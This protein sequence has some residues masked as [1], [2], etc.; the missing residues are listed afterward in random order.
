M[1]HSV[2]SIF[3]KTMKIVIYARISSDK[4]SENSIEAQLRVCRQW[5]EQHGHTVVREYVD[6]GFSAKTAKRDAFQQMVKAVLAGQADAIVVHKLDRFSRN[7]EDSITYKAML[8]RK[9]KQVIS[10]SEPL[11]DSPTDRLL[12]G[13]LE[14]LNE[15]YLLNLAA[16]TQKGMRNLAANGIF[17]LR[18]PMGYYKKNKM[19]YVDPERGPLMTGAFES[20]A[21]GDYTLSEWTAE[22]FRRGLQTK[23]GRKIQKGQ[24]SKLFRNPF[25]L[26]KFMWNDEVWDGVHEPLTDE[27]TWNRVQEILAER[28]PAEG[29][30]GERHRYVFSGYL[31]SAVYGVRMSGNA[32]RGMGGRYYYYRAVGDGPEHNL[33]E[34]EVFGKVVDALKTVRVTNYE[35]V[36]LGDVLRL[37]MQVAQS[38]GDVLARL[39]ESPALQSELLAA[40]LPKDGLVVSAGG[41]ITV[42][43]VEMGFEIENG[44]KNE[45][46]QDGNRGGNR[47]G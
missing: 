10:V 22:S 9:G 32:V 3:N 46:N 23:T 7:R 16:E 14:T 5:A 1:Y 35:I 20:F 25:Y 17:P 19:T 28:R 15:F 31:W 38:V 11:G 40:V 24:W 12:E 26:G 6:H 27:A 44:A 34:K 8:R 43:Q 37:A 36:P 21:T 30:L 39:E 41:E 2:A 18:P 33:P 13:V 29:V 47:V 4:Q 42:R 45:Q